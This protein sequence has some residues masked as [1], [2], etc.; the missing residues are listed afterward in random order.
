MPASQSL[1]I[2]LMNEKDVLTSRPAAAVKSKQE[3]VELFLTNEL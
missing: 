3:V 1:V 2:T